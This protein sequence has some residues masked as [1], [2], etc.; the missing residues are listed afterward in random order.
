MK[1]EN[2][3]QLDLLGNNVESK[4][5][6]ANTLE[7]YLDKGACREQAEILL[8]LEHELK[9]ILRQTYEKEFE[10]IKEQERNSQFLSEH[11]EQ[12]QEEVKEE[13]KE[14]PVLILEI[15]DDKVIGLKI[16]AYTNRN[17]PIKKIPGVIS[18]LTTLKKL[19][20]LGREGRGIEE[21]PESIGNLTSLEILELP[22]NKLS[23]LPES[24]GKLHSLKTNVLT[25]NDGKIK[26]P[27]S[28]Q[29]RRSN[30]TI[31]II[32]NEKLIL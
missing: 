29:E 15:E 14:N 22:Y 24:I 8:L 11:L 23:T 3:P 31:E 30:N 21:L 4:S 26:L 27:K 7:T 25:Q 1:K 32:I 13:F 5:E 28:I 20:I 2:N 9:E 10:R 12:L 16:F 6:Y 17:I 19:K 18:K